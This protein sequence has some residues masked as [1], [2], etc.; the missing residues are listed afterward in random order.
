[1]CLEDTEATQNVVFQQLLHI[2]ILC[3]YTYYGEIQHAS[4]AFDVNFY[5]AERHILQ[6]VPVGIPSECL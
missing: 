1:M 2:C 3:V 5:L 6:C 4:V